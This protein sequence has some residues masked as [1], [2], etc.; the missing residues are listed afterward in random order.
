MW[1]IDEKFCDYLFI[2]YT[3]G[4]PPPLPP[5]SYRSK[6]SLSPPSDIVLKN[7]ATFYICYEPPFPL[8]QVCA[9][10][11]GTSLNYAST[12]FVIYRW[13]GLQPLVHVMPI[14]SPSTYS[15]PARSHFLKVCRQPTCDIVENACDHIHVMHLHCSVC[16]YFT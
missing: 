8:P 3:S 1:H 9:P 2:L 7:L 15:S 4:S 16:L 5:T 6:V 11:R 13:K 12:P 14:W 10:K